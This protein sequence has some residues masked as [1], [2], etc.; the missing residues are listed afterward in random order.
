MAYQVQF[1]IGYTVGIFLKSYYLS[2]KLR[3]QKEDLE[4][5]LQDVYTLTRVITIFLQI[6]Y[7]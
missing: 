4:Y 3:M 2:S 7:M 5:V 1:V 6:Q